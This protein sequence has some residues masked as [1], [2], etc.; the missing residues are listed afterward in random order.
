M[1]KIS[2][3]KIRLKPTPDQIQMLISWQGQIRFIWNMM[4]EIN[5]NKYNSEKKFEFRFDM[6]KRLPTLKKAH[7]WLNAPAHAYQNT[8][9]NLHNALVGCFKQGLGFPNFKSRHFDNPGIEIPQVNQHIKWWADK[10]QI[11]II[12]KI[13]WT[14][15]RKIKGRLL[16]ATIKRDGDQWYVCML[17]EQEGVDQ[18]MQFQEDDCVGI[19]L[20]LKDF[21]IT[22]DGEVFETPKFYR[23]KQKKLKRAQ[24]KLS[25]KEKASRNREKQ[26]KKVA[27]I[28]QKI[29]FQR[30]NFHH[31]LSSAIT[32]QYSVVFVENLNIKGMIKNRSFAKSIADQGWAQ[33]IT[34][35]KYKQQWAGNLLHQIDRWAPSTKACHRCGSKKTITLDERTYVCS[36]CDMVLDR[37]ANAAINIL[38][39]G[40]RETNTAGTA[41]IYAC[42]AI[43]DGDLAL[44]GSSYV[45]LKQESIPSLEGSC[46]SLEQQ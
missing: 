6:Q 32:K 30:S 40:I 23:K 41:E 13:K 43:S 22:S 8:I 14:Y 45:A 16:S 15:H 24:Q 38:H 19:D 10:I 2:A 34:Y 21:A 28:H 1:Q 35:L 18:Q 42:G 46:C 4:L 26:R 27:K 25:R 20:G 3:Y 11:P 39:F 12:G 33:F 31:Q 44:V 36:H 37:D 5:V 17:T 7:K 9:K 29:R